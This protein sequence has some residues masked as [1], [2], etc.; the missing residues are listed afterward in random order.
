MGGARPPRAPLPLRG[1]GVLR[2][3]APL[4]WGRAGGRAHFVPPLAAPPAFGRSSTGLSALSTV[5]SA[6]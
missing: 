2:L 5:A 3:P 6:N 1:S 4:P